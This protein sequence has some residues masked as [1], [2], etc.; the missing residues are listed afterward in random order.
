MAKTIEELDKQIRQMQAQKDNLL[1]K[2]K[3]A[4]RENL[5]R[6][7]IILGGWMLANNPEQVEAVKAELTRDQDRI[8]FGLPVLSV[9]KAVEVTAQEIQH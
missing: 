4:E 9:K 8:A 2:Q 7:K 5:T 3:R 6:Q 1:Q